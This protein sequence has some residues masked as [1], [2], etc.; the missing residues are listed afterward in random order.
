MATAIFVGAFFMF[1][2]A[3][4]W[5]RESAQRKQIKTFRYYLLVSFLEFL[6]IFLSVMALYHALLVFLVIS[7][8]ISTATLAKLEETLSRIASYAKL[9]KLSSVITFFV[10]LVLYVF[11]L[12]RVVPG[13]REI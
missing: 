13:L 7:D 11:S 6:K 9:M 12:Q 8:S 2:V 5:E 3:R 1:F 4:S 10:L